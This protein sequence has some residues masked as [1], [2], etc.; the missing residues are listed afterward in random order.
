MTVYKT[1]LQFLCVLTFFVLCNKTKGQSSLTPEKADSLWSVW[2]NESKHD[3]LRLLA[4]YE[5]AWTGYL[6]T[7]PD[8]A[9]YFAQLS[10]DFAKKKGM[11]KD[12]IKA[13]NT[14][15]G[16]HYLRGNLEEAIE[17]YEES[18]ELSE[19]IDYK[20]GA[21]NALN[22]VGMVYIDKGDYPTGIEKYLK[23]LSIKE[24]IG[25]E[26]GIANSLNN[27]GS[28]YEDLGDYEK[29]IEYHQKSLS[30]SNQL[31][32]KQGMA[33]SYHNVGSIYLN[34]KKLND[35]LTY[36]E[37]S[38]KI[39]EEL[40]NKSGIASSLNSIGNI[41]ELNEDYEKA[42][43]YYNQS[44]L[45][46]KQNDDQQGIASSLNN[47]ASINFELNNINK[48]H[49]Y[50][51]QAHKIAKEIGV[52]LAIKS[53]AKVLYSTYKTQGKTA[54]SLEMLELFLSLKD[55][56]ENEKAVQEVFRREFQYDFEKKQAIQDEKH[57][58]E[59]EKRKLIAQKEEEKKNTII[60]AV[61]GGLLLLVVFSLFIYNRFRITK[62]QKSII[63]S[64]KEI[65]EKKNKEI[66]DS[67]NYAKR[68]QD[69]ILPSRQILLDWLKTGFVFFKPKDVVSGDFYWLE[70]MN[71]KTYFAAADC[72]GHG[73]PGAMISVICSN[74]L[75]KA[76]LEEKIEDP[77]KL[78]D[79]TRELVIQRLEKSGEEVNDGMDISLVSVEDMKDHFNVAFSGANNPLWVISK[80]S[81]IYN[82]VKRKTE[83][84][85]L[86]L[87]EI[88]GDKQ[89][90][91]KNVMS[92][93]FKTH[94]LRLHKED[95]LFIFSDGFQD[96]FGSWVTTDDGKNK[97]G[98]PF[99]GKKFKSSNFKKL[100]LSVQSYDMDTQREKIETSFNKWKGDLEQIDD[101]CVIGVRL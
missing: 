62:K 8:S 2:E 13:L 76:L 65:V 5:Y 35:A 86:F 22:N 28:L 77:G 9:F 25:D 50:A 88:S 63:E 53:S 67:I 69:A 73:V 58:A 32:F 93:P 6:F 51:K 57:K 56:I 43:S 84:N 68:I 94:H 78:L 85:N 36:F 100:L 45:L 75:S 23:S 61:S 49:D 54:K 29:A 99:T 12:M 46:R 72:T 98:V 91:G 42:I 66:T 92:T 31:N 81:E 101:V 20:K 89:A 44:L 15:G 17:Y 82:I 87:H 33:R 3:S 10:Y 80:K 7:Q 95:R 1:I 16:S 96:Q 70:E 52:L 14:Q 64:Q 41:Y 39:E 40:K 97:K 90:I 83:E 34:Q 21:A 24:E 18:Y 4:L 59:L 27:L 48:A 71:G 30:K 60:A 79:R 26:Q 19:K 11:K 38:L 47:L 74:A 37:K 55:S